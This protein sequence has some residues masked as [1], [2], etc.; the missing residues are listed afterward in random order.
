MQWSN[1]NPAKSDKQKIAILEAKLKAEKERNDKNEQ[2]VK[3]LQ[4][5]VAEIVEGGEKD[6][7]MD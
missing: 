1:N 7:L 6:G 2:R 5:I 3:D 4:D